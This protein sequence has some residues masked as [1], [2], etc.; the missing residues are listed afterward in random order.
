MSQ[1]EY[2][3]I[4]IGEL[5]RKMLVTDLLND[6]GQE[7]WELVCIVPNGVAYLKREVATSALRRRARGENR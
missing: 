3:T 5:P 4:N 2:R 7:A 1:W 6:L